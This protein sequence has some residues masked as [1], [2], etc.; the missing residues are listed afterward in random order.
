MLQLELNEF[1]IRDLPFRKG[2]LA[3]KVVAKE[4]YDRAY[5]RRWYSVLPREGLS[6]DGFSAGEQSRLLLVQRVLQLF[7][8]RHHGNLCLKIPV[9]RSVT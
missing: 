3:S 1:G 2:T 8:P 7:I 9:H 6:R 5:P 4:E